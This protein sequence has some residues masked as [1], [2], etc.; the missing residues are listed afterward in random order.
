M[1]SLTENHYEIKPPMTEEIN[2][3]NPLWNKTS[4][5]NKLHTV[6]HCYTYNL[7]IVSTKTKCASVDSISI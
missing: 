5:D 3:A 4:Q 2:I 6:K 1:F 7:A